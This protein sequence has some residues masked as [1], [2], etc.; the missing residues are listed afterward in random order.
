MENIKFFASLNE[1]TLNKAFDNVV[2]SDDE[3]E[4]A[5]KIINDY[6]IISKEFAKIFKT[7]KER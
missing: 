5:K 2:A 3:K 6:K 1:S 4:K 7:I